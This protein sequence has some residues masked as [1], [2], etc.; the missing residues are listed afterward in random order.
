MKN[1]RVLDNEQINWYKEN[2]TKLNY[3]ML[4]NEKKVSNEILE[5]EEAEA[6]EL[7]PEEILEQ[8]RI[9]RD[10]KWRFKV[11]KTKEDAYAQ[12]YEEGKAAG[13]MHAQY[14]LEG[15]LDFINSTI[16]KGLKEWKKRQELLDP[17]ILDLAFEIAET[18]LGFPVEHVEL[19]NKLEST[20]GPL[21]ENID[22][23]SKP[24]LVVSESDY[25]YIQLLKEK[26]A[27]NS[28]IKVRIDQS[29]RSGEYRFEST[30]EVIV[31]NVKNTLKEF[32]KTLPIPTWEQ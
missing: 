28:F 26:Y 4:F 15:K 22:D 25:E 12:G 24:I 14:D 10:Q 1:P 32:R 31:Q 5:L 3:K 13:Y 9:E 6:V 19:K 21:F 23:Q 30:R 11:N 20:L 27:P 7:S 8:A 17:G 18:I 29:C 16:E 2:C